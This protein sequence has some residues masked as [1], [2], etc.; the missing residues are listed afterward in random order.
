MSA[1]LEISRLR[2]PAFAQSYGES[3]SYL[4]LRDTEDGGQSPAHRTYGPMED[5][6]SEVRG[7]RTADKHSTLNTQPSTLRIALLTGGD[8]KP[9]V[10]GLAE[11]LTSEGI[12]FDLIG[13]D[14]LEVPE[15]LR[16]RQIN[17]CNLRGDQ[18]PDASLKSKAFRIL[19][20]YFRIVCYTVGAQPKI[21]HI[22]WNNKFELFDRT[23]LLLYYKLLGKK[24]VFTAHNV[25]IRKRDCT[26]TWLN[27]LS[28]RIQYQLSD[29]IF[30]H[31]NRMK[32]ELASDFAVTAD[33]VSVIPF[34]I[35]NT[36]PNSGITTADAKRMLSVSDS[37][38]TILCYGQ[39]APYKGL[40]YLIDAFSKVASRDA[41]YRLIIAG[42]V[43]KGHVEYWSE[44]RR[45]IAD[46][47]FQ[48][49]IIERIEHIPDEETELYFKAADVLV[50]SYTQVFQS[51]VVFLGYSFGLP[52]IVADVGSLMEEIIEGQTGFVFKPRDSSDLASKIENYFDSELFHNLE[53]RRSQI[54][55]YANERYSWNKVAAIT[56]AIYS[57]L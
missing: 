2:Q 33:K 23:L 28:L 3:R 44:I 30:V 57:N 4:A 43:K 12:S 11:A 10:L 25:N 5:Q 48:N 52:A 31:T 29:H 27:R 1:M 42:K 26:D 39:I 35:N 53:T 41:T 24:L 21:F 15:L 46:S 14:D 13:S 54:R 9:Y 49:Q 50:L 7:Q 20:Y 6:S 45:K 47:E 32:E 34:G 18:R 55:Q 51:G 36:V 56:T 38:K 17:F 16:N 8:D 40:E 19:R 22:L 37:D